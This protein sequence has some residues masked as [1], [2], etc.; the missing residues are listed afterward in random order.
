MAT[1]EKAESKA[2]TK[3]YSLILNVATV[4]V[5]F[6]AGA[7]TSSVF[8]VVSAFYSCGTAIAKALCIKGERGG[9]GEG[10]FNLCIACA[11]VM[12]ASALLY[13]AGAIR[14][15]W[16]PSTVYFGKIPAIA[17]AA[18]SFCDLGAAIAGMVKERKRGS[19]FVKALKRINF[20][21]ALAA[22]VLTQTAILSF[23]DNGANDHA[24]AVAGIIVSVVI[25]ICAAVTLVDAVRGRRAFSNNA[26]REEEDG[27]DAFENRE[28]TT[29]GAL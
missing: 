29:D 21:G 5:K 16:I 8:V 17:I 4:I 1:K 13:C 3:I 22:I 6:A 12:F 19:C 25:V 14:Q 26:L 23:A 18:V 27:E 9:R 24:N 11:G 7:V 10:D 28:N 15:F 2:A 20:T